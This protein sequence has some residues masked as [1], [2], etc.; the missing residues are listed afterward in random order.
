MSKRSGRIKR[1]RIMQDRADR[2]ILPM[3]FFRHTIEMNDPFQM[4]AKMKWLLSHRKV[5]PSRV[6]WDEWTAEQTAK[7]RASVST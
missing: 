4:L 7:L 6:T 3:R 1:Q 2:G 5:R